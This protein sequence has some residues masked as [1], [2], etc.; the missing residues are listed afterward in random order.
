MHNSKTRFAAAVVVPAACLAVVLAVVFFPGSDRAF[1][2]AIKHIKQAQTITCNLTT[3]ISGSPIDVTVD[4]KLYISADHGSRFD[5]YMGGRS[6]VTQYMP[7]DGPAISITPATKTYVR[8][9]FDEEALAADPGKRTPDAWIRELQEL[10]EHASR[11]LGVDTVDGVE[12]EGYEIAGESL[13]LAG[14]AAQLWIDVETS[15]PLRYVI[16]MS[17]PHE[18]SHLKVV[19][20][21]FEWDRPLEAALF[22][23]DVPE[24]YTALDLQMP[25]INEQGL[26]NGLRRFAALSGDAYP[27]SL[28]ASRVIGE[29]MGI[30]KPKNGIASNPMDPAYQDV[31]QGI[32]EVGA[33][34]AFH[35]ELVKNGR[36][37][38]YFGDQVKPDDAD[39]VLM[40]WN[41][42][43]GQRRVV[44]G[45]LRAQ[46]VPGE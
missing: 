3:T 16:E 25:A 44:Y 10:A 7:L 43:D 39:A 15:L 5:M 34:M 1:A 33:S 36:E 35:Q 18:G 11:E 22:E 6:F 12:A 19:H 4:G 8:L 30:L 24:G 45:D 31:L 2:R 9:Q 14:G 40:S 42:D 38:Q 28:D 21:Q 20:D 29:L 23:P 32:M 27:S 13:G 37:P 41:L 26:L 17:G 46:T